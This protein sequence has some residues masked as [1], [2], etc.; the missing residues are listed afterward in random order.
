MNSRLE[1]YKAEY[2]KLKQRIDSDG[3]TFTLEMQL[4]K[5]DLEIKD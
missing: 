2:D 3:D 1:T 5:V 4:R